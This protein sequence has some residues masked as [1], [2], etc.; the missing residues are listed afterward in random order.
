MNVRQLRAYF[1]AMYTGDMFKLMQSPLQTFDV[2]V[3]SVRDAAAIGR[4][5]ASSSD[6]QHAVMFQPL[7][8]L[9]SCDVTA[10]S[11]L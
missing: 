8:L 4:R 10:Q 6:A 9:S 5:S 1:Y 3:I 11:A 7:M 2:N